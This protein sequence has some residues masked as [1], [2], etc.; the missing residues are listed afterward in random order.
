MALEFIGNFTVHVYSK[1]LE[2]D[3]RIC[4]TAISDLPYELQETLL[5]GV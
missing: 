4:P 2:G 3:S 5:Y 1:R